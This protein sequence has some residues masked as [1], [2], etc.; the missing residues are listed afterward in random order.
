METVSSSGHVRV[1]YFTGS[2]WVQQGADIDGEDVADN[3]GES[4]SLSSDG[5]MVAVG[6]WGN[7]N[8]G[9]NAGHV[10]VFVWNGSSWM[11][12][13][14]TIDGE[15]ANDKSGTSVSLNSSGSI[16]AI[17]SPGS[18]SGGFGSGQ[19]R[20][21]TWTGSLWVPMGSAINGERVSP[22]AFGSSVSLS[23]DGTTLAVGAKSSENENGDASGHVRVFTWSGSEWQQKGCN[24][25]GEAAGDQFG[26]SVSLSGDGDTLVV[27]ALGNGDAGSSAG[28]ARIYSW[29]GFEW[30]LNGGDIDG[31]ATNDRFGSAVAVSGDGKLVVVGARGI[32]TGR[33]AIYMHDCTS[34]PTTLPTT[35]VPS[36]VPT[37]VPT[38]AVPSSVPTAVPT[39][40][41]PSTVPTTF[42]SG[43]SFLPSFIGCSGSVL[44]LTDPS[45]IDSLESVNLLLALDGLSYD[46][47]E[48]SIFTTGRYCEWIALRAFDADYPGA[49]NRFIFCAAIC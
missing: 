2:D 7:D 33:V 21:Y 5:N 32:N 26:G 16:L 39:T 37:V 38:T 3:F 4:V 30:V 42:F 19:V 8:N 35:A 34:A 6:A 36:A 46:S 28:Q 41:V 29:T 31:T 1:Y 27:G 14:Q 49:K 12:R 18:S 22:V 45:F 40:A 44:V 20:V 47:Q 11:P 23:M 25:D 24:L 43:P 15:N 13:G 10:R 17:G 48:I 9:A